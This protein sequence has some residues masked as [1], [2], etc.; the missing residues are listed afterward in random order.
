MKFEEKIVCYTNIMKKNMSIVITIIVLIIVVAG[1]LYWQN[2]QE[3][4]RQNKQ[5]ME[6][7]ETHTTV[8]KPSKANQSVGQATTQQ[9]GEYVNFSQESFDQAKNAHRVL[10]FHAPWCPQCRMIDKDIQTAKI[11]DNVTIF[12]T[13]YDSEQSLRQK[14]GVTLQTTFV[15]VD[16][17]GEL[18]KKYV[19]YNEPNYVSVKDNLLNDLPE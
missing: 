8:H 18:L 3:A 11:P 9:K 5:S 16:E 17:N 4:T 12:K 13:D 2:V 10:F 7:A 19:A 1:F 6:S 15:A 14:Y